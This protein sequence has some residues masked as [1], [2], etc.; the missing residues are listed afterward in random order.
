MTSVIIGDKT[1]METLT[2]LT[3]FEEI[4]YVLR[5]E[6]RS[7]CNDAY[8]VMLEEHIYPPFHI[9]TVVSGMA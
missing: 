4:A 6:Y 7:P 3:G 9:T 5:L 1:Y 2:P 8:I